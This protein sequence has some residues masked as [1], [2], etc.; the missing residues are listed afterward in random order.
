MLVI[1]FYGK[2][3][4]SYK[5][6]KKKKKVPTKRNPSQNNLLMKTQRKDE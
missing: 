4:P 2:L 6:Q 1:T 5:G 3:S